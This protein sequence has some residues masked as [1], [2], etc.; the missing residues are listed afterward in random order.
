M[1]TGVWNYSAIKEAVRNYASVPGTSMVSDSSMLNY[2]NRYFR[3]VLPSDLRPLQLQTWYSVTL[4]AGDE[5]YDLKKDFYDT[6]AV[7]GALG[8]ISTTQ[9]RKENSLE[10]YFSPELFYDLWGE[11]KDFTASA[12]RARPSTVLIYENELLFRQCPDKTYYATFQVWRRPL[13][14]VI[15][16]STTAGYFANDTDIPEVSEWGKLIALG[17]ARQITEELGDD[18]GYARCDGLYRQEIARINSQT[19]LW[20]APKR[21]MPKF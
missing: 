20:L 1:T 16:G 7:I 14:Y 10:I 18:E 21:S 17:T 13:V 11:N 19:F 5:D 4:T 2:V 9:Y 15:A 12:N 8:Y 6:Y 3:W